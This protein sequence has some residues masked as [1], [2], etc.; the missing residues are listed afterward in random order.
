MTETINAIP[1]FNALWTKASEDPAV[2]E[3]QVKLN[4]ALSPKNKISIA[5]GF[6]LPS[7]P[8]LNE[9]HSLAKNTRLDGKSITA[10]SLSKNLVDILD[11]T[12]L[13]VRSLLSTLETHFQQG[14]P[15]EEVSKPVELYN[16]DD[17]ARERP[18]TLSHNDYRPCTDEYSL[19][20]PDGTVYCQHDHLAES[21]TTVTKKLGNNITQ[22]IVCDKNGNYRSVQDASK[23]TLVI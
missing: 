16:E 10:T 21:R 8:Y 3:A 6:T 22:E 15:K 17:K 7:A 18:I 19:T 20:T 4:E 23:I 13:I 1:T 5:E 9:L 14:K 11:K 2:K 12:G